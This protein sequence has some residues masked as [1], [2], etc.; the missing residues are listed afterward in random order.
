MA[1]IVAFATGGATRRVHE[2]GSRGAVRL[3]DHLPYTTVCAPV[4]FA[5][6]GAHVALAQ[7]GHPVESGAAVA[8]G[9]S[10]QEILGATIIYVDADATR[11]NTGADWDNALTALQS[12]LPL[13][14]VA[15]AGLEIWVAAG[16]YTPTPNELDETFHLASGVSLYGG[17]A[18]GESLRSERDSNANPTILSG[19]MNGDDSPLPC[20]E[21]SPDCDAN[22]GAC[23]DGFCI[24]RDNISENSNSVVTAFTG[25]TGLIDGFTITGGNADSLALPDTDSGGGIFVGSSTITIVDC[26]VVGNSAAEKGGGMFVAADASGDATV[27]SCR[28]ERNFAG[29]AG[30]GI[31]VSGANPLINGCTF[32]SNRA[33]SLT[34]GGG[35]I[36]NGPLSNPSIRDCMFEGNSAVPNG[37]ALFNEANPRISRSI[38]VRNASSA[39]GGAIFNSLTSSPVITNDFFV[40]NTAGQNGG[41]ISSIAGPSIVNSVFSGNS[42]AV[43]GGAL[44]GGGGTAMVADTT[45]NGNS[46]SGNGGGVYLFSGGMTN[47]ILWANNDASGTGEV[48]QIEGGTPSVNYSIVQGW[49]GSL[50]GVGNSGADPLFADPDGADD[51]PGTT[52]DDLSVMAGSP[53]IDAG[54]NDALPAD[55]ADLDDDLDVTEVTPV[56]LAGYGRRFDDPAIVDSGNAGSLGAPVVDIG[57]YEHAAE[58][59]PIPAA[60]TWGQVAMLLA[61]LA[62]GTITIRRARLCAP[63]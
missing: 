43:L 41:A 6:L 36:Y 14:P 23:V 33:T 19:D 45:V 39:N 55:I 48:A 53:A 38:F 47:T 30:G 2:P 13:D 17:F 51:V 20:A 44:F 22:G 32:T 37:G 31:Y 57:A 52:D 42:A 58:G 5:A 26:V 27:A 63:T 60:S 3:E 10:L 59:N 24:L 61:L 46:A 25:S 56:D 15:G 21:D 54:D 9:D 29:A 11:A 40:G 35:A 50:G 8:Q 16:T 7:I 34:M 49:T 4:L 12:A 28:F 62:G 18:G 1:K